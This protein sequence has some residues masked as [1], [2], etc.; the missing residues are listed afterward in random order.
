MKMDAIIT[1]MTGKIG[2]A[3][4]HG[5]AARFRK[6][7]LPNGPAARFLDGANAVCSNSRPYGPYVSRQHL[8]QPLAPFLYPCVASADS[9]GSHNSTL[10]GDGAA[11][12][13]VGGQE[14]EGLAAVLQHL[15]V[16]RMLLDGLD[17][18]LDA[19]CL[20]DAE[21]ALSLRCQVQQHGACLCLKIRFR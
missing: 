2:A 1:E 7:T 20:D 6:Q 12:V 14:I 11:Q 4:L 10:G 5:P 17:N 18:E 9:L 15:L 21:P 3:S 16:L 19:T 8:L 13:F